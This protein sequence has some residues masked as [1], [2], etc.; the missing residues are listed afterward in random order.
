MHLWVVMFFQKGSSR[1]NAD[2][3][4]S[5]CRRQW[6]VSLVLIRWHTHIFSRRFH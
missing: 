1:H 2:E 3:V 5:Y 4:W 6:P